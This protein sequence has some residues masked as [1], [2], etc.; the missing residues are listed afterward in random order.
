M[1]NLKSLYDKYEISKSERIGFL[2]KILIITPKADFNFK[3]YLKSLGVSPYEVSITYPKEGLPLL[4]EISL[5][6]CSLVIQVGQKI[7]KKFHFVDT[8]FVVSE[9]LSKAVFETISDKFVNFHHHDE[10]SMRDG[11]GTVTQLI[12][13]LK[14][15]QRWFCCVTNHGS[16][17]GWVKQ[18]TNCKKHGIKPIFGC[19]AYFSEYRGDDPEEKKKY[20]SA[21]HLILIAKNEKGYENI[22]K[23]Q[24]D[25]QINGFYYTPRT[26]REA[27]RKWGEGII[28][29]SACLGGLIPRY[30]MNQEFDKAREIL[31]FYKSCFDEFYLELT[32]VEFH[33]QVEVSNALI[34]LAQETNTKILVTVDSH[35]ILPEH[36]ETHNILMLMR[37][38]KTIHDVA[39]DPDDVW[40]FDV[41]G[42]YYRNYDSIVD[43]W[44]DGFY[45]KHPVSG[46]STHYCFKEGGLFTKEILD[47]G[48]ANSRKIALECEDI[49]LDPEVKLPVLSD[50]SEQMIIDECRKGM[51]KL[52]F[53]G[54]EEYEERLK[55]ELDTINDLGWPDYFLVMQKIID[56]TKEKYGEFSVGLGRGSAAGSLVSYCLGITGLDPIE[57]GLLFERFLD[58]SRQ[59]IV[60]S[61]FE[62]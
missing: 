61:D 23:I 38:K 22:I 58:K 8:D 13:L 51:D 35:Y 32:M 59:T 54:N 14:K 31:E 43:L 53:T 50:N 11:L 44:E 27:L 5:S 28:A 34:K 37:Q 45:A 7:S 49:E 2:R 19:E 42:Q 41:K 55:Y 62:V 6:G 26:C 21:S 3:P 10:F 29:S 56:D 60:A 46:E 20:R 9:R 57:H 33:K 1:S 18:Y 48:I 36:E 4:S 15:E 47:E 40:Q 17:G 30:L 12:D 25:A 16:I 52:G 39:E 24:N